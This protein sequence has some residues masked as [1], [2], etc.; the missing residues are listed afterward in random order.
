MSIVA[1]GPKKIADLVAVSASPRDGTKNRS[2]RACGRQ[3]NGTACVRLTSLSRSRAAHI[4]ISQS[5]IGATDMVELKVLEVDLSYNCHSKLLAAGKQTVDT[6]ER[7]EFISEWQPVCP[8][9]ADTRADIDVGGWMIVSPSLTHMDVRP[10]PDGIIR[11]EWKAEVDDDGLKMRVIVGW[12]MGTQPIGMKLTVTLVR[13]RG[14]GLEK[15]WVELV[16]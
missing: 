9:T 6:E 12:W 16:S 8:R 13:D 7:G 1:A 5:N 14:P 3:G 11:W 4:Y 10:S 15:D 2:G